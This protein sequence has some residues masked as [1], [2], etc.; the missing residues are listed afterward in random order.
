MLHK[1]KGLVLRSVKYGESSLVVSIYTELF[2]M[3]SYMVNGVRSAS[4]K[5]PY[6]ANLFQPA[7]ILDLV[8]YQNDRSSLQRIREFKW[9]LIYNDLY[10]N[11]HKNT[12]ALFITEVLQK[13][14]N[15]PEANPELYEFLEDVFT[16]LDEGNP[17]VTANFPLYFLLHLAHFFGFRIQDT[18]SAGNTILDLHEGNFVSRRPQHP[19]YL[20]EELSEI[21]SHLLKTQHP[22]ELIELRLN[23][24]QRKALLDAY[25]S[26]YVFHQP[27]F[28]NLKSIPV[29][30]ALY[31]V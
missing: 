6:R 31:E 15:Q 25:L 30:H 1:T 28:G 16:Q 24:E 14:L 17:A 23:R 18:F 20:E 4:A 27:G 29:L 26:Y 22:E 2:G 3:Q 11:I 7:T 8:V 19:N 5:Q 9:A 13:C 21:T 10:R 12:V